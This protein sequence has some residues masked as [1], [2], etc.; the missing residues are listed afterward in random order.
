MRLP[1]VRESEVEKKKKTLEQKPPGTLG[2][3]LY[4]SQV[5]TVRDNVAKQKRKEMAAHDPRPCRTTRKSKEAKLFK[6]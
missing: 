5:S 1:P 2:H 6:I 3:P 4:F